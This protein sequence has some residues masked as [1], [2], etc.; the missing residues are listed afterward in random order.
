M[1]REK[2]VW[3][4]IRGWALLLTLGV[5]SNAQ[6]HLMG[7]GHCTLNV[8]K[9]KAYIVMSI[10]VSVFSQSG[11]GDAVSDGVLT[12]GELKAHPQT[13]RETIRAGL[14]L[15]HGQTPVTFS[16]ILLNLPKGAHH[17]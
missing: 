13:L 8:V 15:R 12:A 7:R 10:S 14:T 4:L 11:A 5:T 6:A 16:S 9:E 3:H 2:F 17:P 1:S